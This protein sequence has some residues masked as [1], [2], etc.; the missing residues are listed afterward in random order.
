MDQKQQQQ[1]FDVSMGSYD[2][3]EICE[4]VARSFQL[5]PYMKKVWQEKYRLV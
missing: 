3:A 4:L 5:K 2:G 1:L